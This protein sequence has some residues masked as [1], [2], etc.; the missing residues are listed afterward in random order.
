MAQDSAADVASVAT[1]HSVATWKPECNSYEPNTCDGF[2]QRLENDAY[3]EWERHRQILTKEQQQCCETI[4]RDF[5]MVWRKPGADD[6]RRRQYVLENAVL[7]VLEV[8]TIPDSAGDPEK[9]CLR[10]LLKDV[11]MMELPMVA[12]VLGVDVN[13]DKFG[14]VAPPRGNFGPP[15]WLQPTPEGRAAARNMAL[16]S[17]E[18][19]M[20]LQ[21]IIRASPQEGGDGEKVAEQLHGRVVDAIQ[22]KHANFLVKAIIRDRARRRT[23]PLRLRALVMAAAS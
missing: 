2:E 7:P 18:S 3:A 17:K 6:A 20:T 4:V 19:S 12:A 21:N 1:W 22:D 23:E 5:F 14:V 15:V 8:Y 10:A 16:G 9:Q 13:R 11:K